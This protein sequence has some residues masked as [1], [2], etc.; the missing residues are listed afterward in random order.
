MQMALLI[1][2][3]EVVSVDVRVV[4]SMAVVIGTGLVILRRIA[5]ASVTVAHEASVIGSG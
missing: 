2:A 4:V 3:S 1:R 5:H